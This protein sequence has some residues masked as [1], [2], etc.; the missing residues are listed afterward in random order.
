MYGLFRA[1][2]ASLVEVNPYAELS[3]GSLL[4]AD[5]KVVLDDNGLAKH[6]E[7]E[8]YRNAE[9]YSAE[10]T[11]A[12]AAGLSFVSLDGDIG[13]IVN[14]PASAAAMDQIEA[15]WGPA[16]FLAWAAAQS[17]K[18]LT[19]LNICGPTRA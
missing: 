16:N 6:P 18:V 5:A 7:L 10:E 3:D 11:A 19:A 9:E 12:R 8:G 15:R 2:D 13:C 1:K 17:G 4:A 14:G